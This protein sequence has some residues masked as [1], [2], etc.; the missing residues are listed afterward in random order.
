M[1]TIMRAHLAGLVQQ[2]WKSSLPQDDQRTEFSWV[3]AS[4]VLQ[5]EF[6]LRTEERKL[7][8]NR[9]GFGGLGYRL[10]RSAESR[11][12]SREMDGA[13]VPLTKDASASP[14]SAF[15]ASTFPSFEGNEHFHEHFLQAAP[16]H[17]HCGL[18]PGV[19]WEPAVMEAPALQYSH[20][21]THSLTHTL[22]HRR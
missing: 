16:A 1:P 19:P 7:L 13:T 17:F 2:P 15:P 10:K 22:T 5:I 4:G 12:S 21:F 14:S 18:G 11:T 8:K 9:V 6:F 3:I 20:T